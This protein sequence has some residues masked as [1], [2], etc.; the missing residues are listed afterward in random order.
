[1]PIFTA[2]YINGTGLDTVRNT[3]V[4]SYLSLEGLGIWNFAYMFYGMIIVI[5]NSIVAVLNPRI[6]RDY[7]QYGSLKQ[8]IH[9]YIKTLLIL[10]FLMSVCSVVGGWLLTILVPLVIP[11]YI[12][13][14]PIMIALLPCF[15]LRSF[16]LLY[17]MLLAVNDLKG[18]NFISIVASGAQ[19]LSILV[20][21]TF[22][23]GVYTFPIAL[24]LGI[25][26]RIGLIT[27]RIFVIMRRNRERC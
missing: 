23:N 5:P 14:I 27:L 4:L 3:L 26:V 11:N 21:H 24:T 6:I 18:I 10:F 17:S 2:S 9:K 20:I 22:Y 8:V 25:I 15:A 12:K 7:G 16:E 19:L 13:S 1:M